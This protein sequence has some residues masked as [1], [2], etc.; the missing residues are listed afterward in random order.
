MAVALI[1]TSGVDWKNLIALAQKALNRPITRTADKSVGVV[2]QS[3]RYATALAEFAG[4]G[5][6]QSIPQCIADHK[7]V[8]GLLHF[9]FVTSLDDNSLFSLL[10]LNTGLKSLPALG[11]SL[12]IVGGD[13]NVWVSTVLACCKRHQPFELQ[14]FG[15]QVIRIFD[16]LG[17]GPAWT[18]WKRQAGPAGVLLLEKQ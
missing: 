11:V 6:I 18:P 1:E 8:Y 12:V 7:E 2:S 5:T 14:E 17:L 3:V 10:S 13:L 16:T 4:T 9:T 15:T